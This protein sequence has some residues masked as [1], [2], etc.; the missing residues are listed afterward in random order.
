MNAGIIGGGWAGFAAAIELARAGHGVTV[1]EAG[2]VLG[3]RARRMA[4][5]G[6]ALDN[7]QHLL[8][9]AYGE[10]LRL[11]ELVLPG[12]SVSGFLRLPL[13]LV[14]PDGVSIRAPRLP[15][16]LRPAFALLFA[17]GLTL[18]D[19]LAAIGFMQALK[20]I[21]FAPTPDI[22]VAEALAGQPVA[23]RKYLWEPICVAALNTPIEQASFRV[24]A[25]VLKDALTGR[26]AN[27]DFLIPARDL[28]ALFP[29]PAAAWL[30]KNGGEVKT[31]TRISALQRSGTQWKVLWDG[32]EALHDKL[33][34]AT[35]PAHA[36]DLLSPLNDCRQIVRGLGN[37]SYQPILTVYAQ[38][39]LLPEFPAPLIG[40]VEPVPMFIFDMQASLGMKDTI[41]VVASASGPHLEWDDVRWIEEIEARMQQAF[42]PL[43]PPRLIRR[44]TE[45]RAT[46]TCAPGMFRPAAQTP[47]AGLFLAG[48]YVDGPY[49]AT[50][51]GAVKS[52]VQCAQTLLAT[53]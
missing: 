6:P 39:D 43:P 13:A 45:K 9:G 33:I 11:M 21:D 49:P 29:E 24:F 10:T 30:E 23:V 41:S 19:K 18:S 47:C 22:T 46:Y 27:S 4:T 17:R 8:A 28:S 26:A 50:L 44:I 40:W 52:G 42:G 2:R 51:E 36:V 37:Y 31:R 34:V 5:D 25:R 15:A 14:Y 48:D 16:P 12:S 1:Y 7:G 35:A 20:K 38:Y 3:G 53:S 32:G